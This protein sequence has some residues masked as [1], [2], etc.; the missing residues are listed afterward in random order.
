MSNPPADPSGARLVTESDESQAKQAPE[1]RATGQKAFSDTPHPSL[2][3]NAD[4]EFTQQFLHV[5]DRQ[6]LGCATLS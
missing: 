1:C 3:H 2:S 6:R 5:G 4:I